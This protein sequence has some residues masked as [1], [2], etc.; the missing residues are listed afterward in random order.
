MGLFLRTIIVCSFCLSVVGG[1]A[2]GAGTV[3][4]IMDGVAQSVTIPQAQMRAWFP[5]ETALVF[6]PLYRARLEP[7]GVIGGCVAPHPGCIALQSTRY[8]DAVRKVERIG[9]R[10]DDIARFVER[11]AQD[12]DVAPVDARFQM[13]DGR[14]TV[15]VPHRDGIAMDTAKAVDVI[16]QYAQSVAQGTVPAKIILPSRRIAP[17]FTIAEVNNLGITTLLAEGRSNFAGSPPSRVHNIKTAAKRF[18][19]II[20]APGEELSFVKLLGPVDGTTGYAKELVI[21]DNQT[22]PE[23]GGGICQVSTTLFR[24]AILAGME[25]T[26]RRNHSYA[27]KYYQPTGFD[28]TIYA[29][30][31]D[32]RF[33]NNTAHHILIENHIEGTELVFRIY[34]TPDGRTVEMKGPFVTEKN[35]DGSMKTYFTQKVIA[36]DGTVL[37]DDIFYSNYKSPKDYPKPADVATQRLT[38]KPTNWSKKQWRNYQRAQKR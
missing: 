13:V 5:L 36:A 33:K 19:G 23:Y 30:Y 17:R 15:F 3:T 12:M 35:P 10:R 6:D 38:K 21:K 28:A 9:V 32:L 26:Q 34:G 14:V 11:L 22:K 20:L 27:I 8:A 31:P 2:H 7:A 4:F 16:A 24:S 29:P 18:N 25:I 37:I 1:V